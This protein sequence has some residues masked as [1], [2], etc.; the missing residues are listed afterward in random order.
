MRTE[1]QQADVVHEDGDNLFIVITL[2]DGNEIHVTMDRSRP[3][4]GLA[5]Y[6]EG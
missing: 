2:N 5:Y 1:I 3:H 4:E 6:K